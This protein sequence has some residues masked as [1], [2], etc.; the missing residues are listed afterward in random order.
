MPNIAS[1]LSAPDS[2]KIE[3]KFLLRHTHPH[4]CKLTSLHEVKYVTCLKSSSGDEIFD[5]PYNTNGS[6]VGFCQPAGSETCG[7]KYILYIHYNIEHC[8]YHT[9][10]NTAFC[11]L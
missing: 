3:Y 8:R 2:I 10:V 11:N 1:Y 4:Q 5:L 7:N 9:D 6:L